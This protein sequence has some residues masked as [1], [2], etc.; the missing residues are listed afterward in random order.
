[1]AE[2]HFAEPPSAL[3]DIAEGVFEL[4][5]PRSP[6]FSP[7]SIEKLG[8]LIRASDGQI[9]CMSQ[10]SEDDPS[11]QVQLTVAR[12]LR[13][14]LYLLVIDANPDQAWFWTEEWQAGERAVDARLAAGVAER[15]YTEEELDAAL[16]AMRA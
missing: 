1:M 11:Q 5:A 10:D 9:A 2:P 7:Q 14:A 13:R 4:S 3:V 8:Q 12:A 16:R 15:P 6:E